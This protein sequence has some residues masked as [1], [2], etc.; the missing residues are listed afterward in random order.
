MHGNLEAL[1]ELGQVHVHA[2]ESV[3]IW[4][5]RVTCVGHH[6]L[7]AAPQSIAQLAWSLASLNCAAEELLLSMARSLAALAPPPHGDDTIPAFDKARILWAYAHL[8]VLHP[9]MMGRLLG[10]L[11]GQ[12]L[13]RMG[14]TGV[15]AAVWACA[16]LGY[17]RGPLLEL[18]G[19]Y[20]SEQ[21]QDFS[22][23]QLLQLG[24]SL[25]K[26]GCQDQ[27]LLDAISRQY[28]L[29]VAERPASTQA[30]YEVHLQ[31]QPPP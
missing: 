20:V 26:L 21:I 24:W 27:L 11:K 12:E 19:E 29:V 13:V 15:A 25:A 14:P 9:P 4:G 17:D 1:P 10:G 16:K 5:V 22:E 7:H 23:Q 3:H 18:V 6:A 30:S 2:V 8:G 28:E 31:P